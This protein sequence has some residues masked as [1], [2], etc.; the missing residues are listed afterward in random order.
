MWLGHD[1]GLLQAGGSN[2]LFDPVF[3]ER[4]SPFSLIGPK[5]HNPPPVAVKDLPY[6]DAVFISHN[7]Y[8]HLDKTSVLTV[9][10]QPGGSPRLFVP[11]GLA[12][13]FK[14]LGMNNV[15][16]LDWW[17]KGHMSGADI[18]FVPA[19]HGSARGLFD[20]NKS[21]WGGW[22]A[23]T[24]DWRFY[25]A[26]DAGWSD[27]FVDIGQRVPGIDLAAIP[28]GAYAPRWFMGEQHVNPK[29]AVDLY[30]ASGAKRLGTSLGYSWHCQQ[31]V[32][33]VARRRG[34]PAALMADGNNHTPKVELSP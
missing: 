13:W 24:A 32:P 23:T 4:A 7:H 25:F 11:L 26:G 17:D 10:Q 8:D 9:S 21:L 34:Y 16:E 22:I 6:M 27:D 33:C 14:D 31:P 18:H 28:I 30:Q 15:V 1:T 2:L 20:T 12:T 19:H 29:E 5:R 3:S